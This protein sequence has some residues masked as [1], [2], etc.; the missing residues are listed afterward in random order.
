MVF[1]FSISRLSF[2]LASCCPLV[3]P[4]YTSVFCGFQFAVSDVPLDFVGALS[5]VLGTF[6]G[7]PW[8]SF[9]MPCGPLGIHGVRWA[10]R[11]RIWA[12]LGSL[13]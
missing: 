7:R 12:A 8:N 6:R 10:P 1:R 2:L 5:Q 13:C 3:R 4:G 11:G 9:G